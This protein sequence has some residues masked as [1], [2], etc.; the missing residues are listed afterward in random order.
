MKKN[1]ILTII[2]AFLCSVFLGVSAQAANGDVV[3]TIYS[4]DIKACING[5]WVDSYNIGGKTVVIV[6]D[7]TRQFEYSD[8]LRTL[9]LTELNPEYLVS[10]KMSYNQKPGTPVGKIYE[11]DIKTYFRGKE[12]TSYS[13]N[14]KMAVVVEELG[15]DNAFSDIGGKFIWNADERTISLESMYSFPYEIRNM[16]EDEH[17]NI[18]LND[19]DG[20]LQAERAPAPLAGGHML[21][22]MDTPD[23]SMIPVLYNNEIIGYRCSFPAVRI[24]EDESGAYSLKERQTPVDYFYV[25]K[26]KDII[27]NGEPVQLTYQDWLNYYEKHT[28]MNIKDSFETDEYVFLYAHFSFF[29]DGTDRLIKLNKADGTKIEYDDSF[30]SYG[31]KYLENVRIDRENEKVY[32]DDFDYVID[33][34]TDEIKYYNN[35]ATD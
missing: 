19:V 22:E 21:C 33:L 25:D 18:I 20:V 24:A 4:T 32:V 11:T 16:L 31:K 28:L 15:W 12:L 2:S 5:V 30:I 8:A 17:L 10:G 27:Y 23:N 1:V 7:I 34:K 13:L 26:I 6:E 14:G 29:H 9:V 3:G 35:L